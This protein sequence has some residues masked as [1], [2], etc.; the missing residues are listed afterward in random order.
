M[1]SPVDTTL[2]ATTRPTTS[3]SICK[4]PQE[5][6]KTGIIQTCFLAH[7]ARGKLSKEA[8]RSDQNL[9]LLVG[10]ANLLGSLM[11]DPA[12][13]EQE[14][15]R[16]YNKSEPD[17]CAET[18]VEASE[19]DWDAESVESTDIDSGYDEDDE[20]SKSSAA[21]IITTTEIESDEKDLED[22]EENYGELALM[23]HAIRAW[24]RR[25]LRS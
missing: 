18:A 23:T 21:I 11:I 24:Q 20:T 17:P 12:S 2:P 3:F 13:A 5:N 15:E 6:Q 1:P 16:C 4:V 8:S 7:S 10:H 19:A 22:D 9:L 14:Q 25:G